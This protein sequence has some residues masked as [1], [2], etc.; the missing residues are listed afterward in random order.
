[1]RVTQ[2]DGKNGIFHRI[3]NDYNNW[4]YILSNF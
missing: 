2:N 3:I 4:K 1:L